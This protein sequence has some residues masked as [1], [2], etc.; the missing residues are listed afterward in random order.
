M[1][2]HR[3]AAFLLLASLLPAAPALAA[4]YHFSSGGP[5][6]QMAAVSQPGTAGVEAEAAD[7]FLLDQPTTITHATFTGLFAGGTGPANPSDVTV[8]IYRVFPQDSTVP[9][10][11]HVP[12]RANS[13][14]DVV[15]A[16]RDSAASGLTFTTSVLSATFTALNSVQSGGIHPVPGQTTGGNGPL[17]GEEVEFDVT[18]TSPLVLPAGHYFF[19][20]QVALTGGATFYW[21]SAPKPITGAG[22][23]FT[24]DLQSWIRD[25]NLA[26]DW[27]R[28]G[29][30]IVGS[31]GGAAPPAFNAAFT[32]D[33]IVADP[34]PT[35]STFGFLALALGLAA[36]AL[37]RLRS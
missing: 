24:P 4:A 14:S 20:P 1:M 11:S 10:S 16:S 5:D 15:L 37:Q 31:A 3:T 18:F 6:N 21:L 22:T 17:T 7:D 26:P 25:A 33:G 8:E 35:L 9:P 13:P 19:V 36:V 2:H 32:L 34:V 27:L 12:T 28:L 23:P 30:D 29:T